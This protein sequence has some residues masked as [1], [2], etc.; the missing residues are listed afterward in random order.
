MGHHH[1]RLRLTPEQKAKRK[2]GLKRL[3]HVLLWLDP[4]ASPFMVGKLIHDSIKKRHDKKKASPQQT[5]IYN[6]LQTAVD[7][8][9]SQNYVAPANPNQYG[10]TIDSVANSVADIDNSMPMSAEGFVSSLFDSG[11]AAVATPVANPAIQA[12]FDDAVKK[13]AALPADQKAD[14]LAAIADIK[15]T[16]ASQQ[17]KAA[18]VVKTADKKDVALASDVVKNIPLDSVVKSTSNAE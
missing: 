13:A 2:K 12:A 9:A 15:S 4:V 6:T 3:L 7:N 11:T 17:S 8:T 18:D 16:V 5:Q 14:T 10:T 1:K